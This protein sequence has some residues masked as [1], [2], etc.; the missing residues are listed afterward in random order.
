M[1]ADEAQPT[2]LL[3]DRF[4]VDAGR[5]VPLEAVWAHGSLALGDYRPGR[6]NLVAL[7]SRAVTDVQRRQLSVVHRA[8]T[9]DV[10][11]AAKLHCSYAVRSARP[12]PAPPR[13]SAPSTH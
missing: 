11:M 13:R 8:L 2:R 4:I 10:P 7:V 3:L 6:S 5:A 1:H 9:A 12:T